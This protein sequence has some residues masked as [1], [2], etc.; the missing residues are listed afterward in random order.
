MTG[1]FRSGQEAAIQAQRET[2]ASELSIE[3][4]TAATI[5]TLLEQNAK[6]SI[7]MNQDALDNLTGRISATLDAVVGRLS[8][9]GQQ[10][11][12]VSETQA[13]ISITQSDIAET[14]RRTLELIANIETSV[15]S[16]TCSKPEPKVQ[17]RTQPGQDT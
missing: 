7:K 4:A 9:L 5:R 15:S 3:A 1:A 8:D 6:A 17:H 14:Q 12:K 13:K 11:D 2:R 16:H 10:L